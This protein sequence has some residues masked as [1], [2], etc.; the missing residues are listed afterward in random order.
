MSVRSVEV[1]VE[2]YTRASVPYKKLSPHK[3]RSTYGTALYQA[4]GDI[5]LVADV[6][7]HDDITT[8]AK[9][10]SAVE[11]EHR[12]QAADTELYN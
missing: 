4:T 5:R 1:M 2:K 10:Y 8:T 3:M 9:H 6:L 11:I 7:G 12:R